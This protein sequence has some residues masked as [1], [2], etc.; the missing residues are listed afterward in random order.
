LL[1]W[2]LEGKEKF[3]WSD[4]FIVKAFFIIGDVS[5]NKNGLDEFGD[6][7]GNA[8]ANCNC[9]YHLGCGGPNYYC[10]SE[11]CDETDEGCGLF[12]TSSCTGACD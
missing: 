5:Y 12:G 9:R 8:G 11:E 1:D 4:E 3:N 7:A 10:T 2:V 6:P